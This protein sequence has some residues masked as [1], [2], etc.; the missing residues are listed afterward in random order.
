MD[1]AIQMRNEILS[2][3]FKE[4]G[5][6]PTKKELK[7]LID[8]KPVFS[9]LTEPMVPEEYAVSIA[10]YTRQDLI[11][12]IKDRNLIDQLLVDLDNKITRVESVSNKETEELLKKSEDFFTN[13]TEN[14][15]GNILN[16]VPD[17][18]SEADVSEWYGIA[19]GVDDM[20][21][22][23]DGTSSEPSYMHQ[24]IELDSFNV[25]STAAGVSI[26]PSNVE[27]LQT[28][29]SIGAYSE[30]DTSILQTLSTINPISIIAS[31][32]EN[33]N[34]G[35]EIA[36]PILDKNISTIHLSTNAINCTVVI[37]GVE[38]FTKSLDGDSIL[39]IATNVKSE[40]KLILFDSPTQ[41]HVIVKDIAIYT[42][43]S[44]AAGS[45]TFGQY[46]TLQLPIRSDFANIKFNPDEYN[47]PGTNIEW[48]WSP[49]RIEWNPLNK[50]ETGEYP[51]LTWNTDVTDEIVATP[52][53]LSNGLSTIW[54]GSYSNEDIS[55]LPSIY[56]YTIKQGKGC[57]LFVT[58]D[59]ATYQGFQFYMNVIDESGY[60]LE[61]AN[62]TTNDGDNLLTNI[63]IVSDDYNINQ[64]ISENVKLDIPFGIHKVDLQ[65]SN[66]IDLEGYDYSVKTIL[67]VLE[68]DFGAKLTLSLGNDRLGREVEIWIQPYSL[69]DTDQHELLM[70]SEKE[71]INR[72]CLLSRGPLNHNGLYKRHYSLAIKQL[73]AGTLYDVVAIDLENYSTTAELHS[74]YELHYYFGDGT[75]DW[76]VNPY[77]TPDGDVTMNE[78]GTAYTPAQNTGSILVANSELASTL[79]TKKEFIETSG[80]NSSVVFNLAESPIGGTVNVIGHNRVNNTDLDS[81]NPTDEEFPTF[82]PKGRGTD[83]FTAS[84]TAYES[85]TVTYRPT[86]GYCLINN[87]IDGYIKVPMDCP[88]S[89]GT[90]VT[91]YC[92]NGTSTT[93]LECETDG[94]CSDAAFADREACTAG[95]GTWTPTY[96]WT[97]YI[98][99]TDGAT[100]TYDIGVCTGG[101]AVGTETMAECMDLA[102]FGE[103]GGPAWSD[104]NINSKQVIVRGLNGITGTVKITYDYGELQST[105]TDLE[106]VDTHEITAADNILLLNRSPKTP[107]S[108]EVLAPGKNSGQ[109]LT[110]TYDASL[111]K[112]KV[113]LSSYNTSPALQS[114]DVVTL[115]YNAEYEKTVDGKELTITNSPDTSTTRKVYKEIGTTINPTTTTTLTMEHPIAFREQPGANSGD[116]SNLYIEVNGNY[117]TGYCVG[118][119]TT[120]GSP[121]ASQPT[122][123]TACETTPSGGDAG[124]WTD[125]VSN[126]NGN[127]ITLDLSQFAAG[128]DATQDI[129]TVSVLY[130]SYDHNHPWRLEVQYDY[131]EKVPYTFNYGYTEVV[132][133]TFEGAGASEIYNDT[134]LRNHFY[135]ISITQTKGDNLYLKAIL[136]SSGEETP[137]IRRIRFER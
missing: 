103:S 127:I 2:R 124:T 61:L 53:N 69:T 125:L 39:S 44:S 36:M 48:E 11:D 42:S 73:E 15:Y 118:Y 40:L 114:G 109:T 92:N 43:S 55:K 6:M 26:S 134:T 119:A 126:I 113:D 56:E 20:Y 29:L 18:A 28:S 37:D 32:L 38:L 116:N 46:V 17:L 59:M 23:D 84:G 112:Y 30:T 121:D 5:R 95:S 25:D 105:L 9:P 57:V 111:D 49:S 16:Q 54:D 65:I 102:N 62:T 79:V 13:T 21:V 50:D 108:V 66:I 130:E 135:D 122:D 115:L 33:I 34:K 136:T 94:Y 71:K 96:G 10:D 8:R 14:N 107:Y 1:R 58:K 88:A 47:P 67:K 100:T 82:F 76:L 31:G 51:R 74:A 90:W 106:M 101:T 110:A 12:L 89:T 7:K 60:T 27:Q 80:E 132:P 52:I 24:W 63:S 120:S 64:A 93:Q 86:V 85:F 22:E 129:V 77:H 70:H 3:F 137:I 117:Y 97:T 41:V 72:A 123:K 35:I 4:N 78:S 83:T 91:G 128:D 99:A 133:M 98:T 68:D 45:Y 104:F 87:E 19:G 81:S 131:Y 75:A